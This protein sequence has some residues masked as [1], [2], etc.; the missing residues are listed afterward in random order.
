[1]HAWIRRLRSINTSSFTHMI[2]ERSREKKR[3]KLCPFF[4]VR[5]TYADTHSPGC[6]RIDSIEALFYPP[7]FKWSRSFNARLS[8]PPC[9]V[10]CISFDSSV[11]NR[12]SIGEQVYLLPLC[13]LWLCGVYYARFT[14]LSIFNDGQV[15]RLCLF[16]CVCAKFH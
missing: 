5:Y 15:N 6:Y 16:V 12:P 7:L 11:A 8:Q 10:A 14:S 13:A 9:T 4:L 1:M 3:E 2:H